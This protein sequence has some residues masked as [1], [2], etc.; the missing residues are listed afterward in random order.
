M[1]GGPADPAGA[2]ASAGSLASLGEVRTISSPAAGEV[3]LAAARRRALGLPRLTGWVSG[4]RG[5]GGVRR[6]SVSY[7]KFIFRYFVG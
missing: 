3:W 5:V 6:R 1:A 4:G 2:A 7:I